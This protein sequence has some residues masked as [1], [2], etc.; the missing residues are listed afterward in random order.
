MDSVMTYEDC[1]HCNTEQE[2]FH[3]NFYYKTGEEYAFCNLC[4]YGYT[5]SIRR[6]ENGEPVLLDPEKGKSFDNVI[7]DSKDY[8]NPYGAYRLEYKGQIGATV[9]CLANEQEYLEFIEHCTKS[10]W[11]KE[12]ESAIVSKL[13]SGKIVKEVIRE[14]AK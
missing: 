4:G 7:Y 2:S 11:S 1:P 3:V 12:I 9:G 10:T 8:Q 13:V 5:H 14:H 6:D